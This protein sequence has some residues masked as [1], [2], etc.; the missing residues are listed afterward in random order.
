VWVGWGGPAGV[1][2]GLGVVAGGAVVVAFIL[3][4]SRGGR[5]RA[6]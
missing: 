5:A 1:Y 4:R 2:F 6:E 3:A